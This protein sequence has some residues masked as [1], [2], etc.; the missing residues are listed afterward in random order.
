MVDRTIPGRNEN[1]QTPELTIPQKQLDN[2]WESCVTLTNAWGWRAKPKF[3]SATWVI[4]TLVEVVAKGGCLALN[5]GPTPEG[6]IEE[7]T[8]T[9]LKKVG[10]WL[11][12]NG[13]AIYSTRTTPNYNCGK[14]WFTANKNGKTLYA[15]YTLSDNEALPK[16]IEWEGNFPKGKMTLLQNGKTVKYLCKKG[17]VIVTLPSDIKQETLAFSFSCKTSRNPAL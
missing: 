10:Q 17:K 14:V 9:R 6:T 8:I 1:Y 5:V 2:P 12:T 11:K 16:Q 15:I 4:N 13:T 7:G 3:K